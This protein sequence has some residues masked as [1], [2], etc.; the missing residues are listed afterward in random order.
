MGKKSGWRHK[1]VS[2]NTISFVARQAWPGNVRELHH[3]LLQ[4]AVM[5]GSD[6]IETADI[7]AAIAEMPDVDTMTRWIAALGT[8]SA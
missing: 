1:S 6:T 4:A 7:K 5:S 2:Y 3:A 8:A